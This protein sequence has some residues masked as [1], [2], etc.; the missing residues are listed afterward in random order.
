MKTHDYFLKVWNGSSGEIDS[1][2]PLLLGLIYFVSMVSVD[3]GTNDDR[4]FDTLR[5][6]GLSKQMGENVCSLAGYSVVVLYSLRH[7]LFAYLNTCD[8]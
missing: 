4:I 7:H 2:H 8:C 3:S 5:C 6:V 1:F